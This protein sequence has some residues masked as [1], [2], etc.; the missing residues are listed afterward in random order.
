MAAEHK[1]IHTAL[2]KIFTHDPNTKTNALMF[3]VILE[4]MRRETEYT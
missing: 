3:L 1:A 4:I 2:L